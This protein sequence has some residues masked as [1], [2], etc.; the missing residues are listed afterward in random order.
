VESWGGEW[1]LVRCELCHSARHFIEGWSKAYIA[2]G[3]RMC[4]KCQ[5]CRSEVKCKI[6]SI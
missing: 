1:S 2:L 4:I 6:T 3:S 5:T